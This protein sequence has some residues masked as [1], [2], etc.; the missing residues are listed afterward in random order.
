MAS[1]GYRNARLFAEDVDLHALASEVGTP[2]YCYSSSAIEKA[3]RDF[4]AALEGLDAKIFYALKANSN[5]AVIA[6]LAKLGA[7]ADVVSEGEMLRALGA[8]IAPEKIVFAGVGKSRREL[9][10]A[11]DAGI[12]Q[13]N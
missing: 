2:F 11:L 8:G 6:T 4:A 1:F 3:Y 5:Q 12:L 10:S 9:E 13:F 7:G